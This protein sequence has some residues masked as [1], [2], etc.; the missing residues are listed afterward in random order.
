MYSMILADIIKRWQQLKGRRALLSTGVD[1]HG[2]KVQKAAQKADK[3]TN[4]FCDSAAKV[5]SGLAEHA[6]VS[7]D[8]FART[9]GARHRDAVQ[10]AWSML[11]DK[12]YI[13]ESKHE[14]WYSISDETFVPESGV[15][16][17][18][19]P[20]TGRKRH[21]SLETGKVVEWTSETNYKF[22]LSAFKDQLLQ[23]YKDNPEW[24]TPRFQYDL[25]RKEVES[26]LQD[27]SV[28]R[29]SERVQWGIQVPHDPSQNIYVWL[30]ALLNY[31]V[32]AGYP[33]APEKRFAGGWPADVQVIGKD[34]I[35]FH[36]IYWPAF[37]I[38][39]DLPPPKRIIAHGH[40]TI[41]GE[42]MS[43]STGNVVNPFTIVNTYG[44]D[45]VRWF[46]ALEGKMEDDSDYNNLTLAAKYEE[47]RGKLGNF[48]TRLVRSKR[49]NMRKALKTTL[50]PRGLDSLHFEKEDEAMRDNIGH[51]RDRISPAVD[52]HDI[53]ASLAQIM[54]TI[55][56]ANAYFHN[57]EPWRIVSKY[58]DPDDMSPRLLTILTLAAESLRICGILLQ[59][60][61]PTKASQLLDQLGVDES[62]RS[63]QHAVLGADTE[64]GQRIST[65][66][67]VLFPVIPRG[68]V[69]PR[70]GGAL[71]CEK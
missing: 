45:A 39:L 27:L 31:T 13:Y 49:W 65:T 10:Y 23:H 25:V 58:G 62:H 20:A 21:I 59:P 3:P 8:Y 71:P 57:Q 67:K 5:F 7:N 17:A 55:A 56:E 35:R 9:T 29:P 70:V 38:A 12:E 30:D 18:V 37:L 1:E 34:I 4:E 52:C 46:L 2:L 32:Q 68:L 51:L 11:Q 24:I 48:L 61:M 41:G 60:Y 43:K 40:W 42:K 36:C 44:V 64:Y 47:M 53:R 14:G 66:G 15:D 22:R 63:W 54:Q 33:W 16:I 26:G 6:H 28:S 50:T 69:S 19:D